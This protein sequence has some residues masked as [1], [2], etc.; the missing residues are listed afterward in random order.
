M[1]PANRIGNRK[2]REQVLKRRTPS[3]GYYIIVTDTKET[4]Q[5]YMHGL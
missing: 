4:E 1:P 3:L 5:S 2:S